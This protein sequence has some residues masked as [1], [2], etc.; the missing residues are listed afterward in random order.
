MFSD[1]IDT[2]TDPKGSPFILAQKADEKL[3]KVDELSTGPRDQLY[4][5]LRIAALEQFME[6]RGPLPL[7]LD[8]LFVN[9]DDERTE[10]GLR[11]LDALADETQ[12]LLFTHHDH[13]VELAKVAVPPDRLVVHDLEGRH[14][15]GGTKA[16]A[17]HPV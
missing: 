16:R 10:A 8:D 13:I 11:V 1:G 15:A 6:R 14:R 7:V 12:V 5:S 4:L 2:D 9:F 17:D 3:L